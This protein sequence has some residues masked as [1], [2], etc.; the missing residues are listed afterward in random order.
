MTQNGFYIYIYIY[1][2]FG[3]EYYKFC[4]CRT[5]TLSVS[6]FSLAEEVSRKH[7]FHEDGSSQYIIGTIKWYITLMLTRMSHFEDE[8][9][10]R[11]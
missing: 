9:K 6:R 2:A 8:D 1:I 11:F 3:S 4:L 7:T 10:E 5:P